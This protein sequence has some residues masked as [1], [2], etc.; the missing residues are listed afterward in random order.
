MDIE[1]RRETLLRALEKCL[2]PSGKEEQRDY[3]GCTMITVHANQKEPAASFYA[4]DTYLCVET[5]VLVETLTDPGKIAVDTKRLHLMASNMPGDSVHLVVRDGKLILTGDRRRRY[6][7]TTFDPALFPPL[8]DPS[9]EAP[10]IKM[11]GPMLAELM[12][13][14]EHGCDDSKQRPHLAGILL[15]AFTP[16]GRQMTAVEAVSM[17]GYKL[18]QAQANILVGGQLPFKAFL[19]TRLLKPLHGVLEKEGQISIALDNASVFVMTPDTLFGALLPRDPFINYEEMIRQ[20]HPMKAICS[21]P[22]VAMVDSLK[23]ISALKNQRDAQVR[24][25]F[26]DSTFSMDLVDAQ[27]NASD[28]LPVKS[29]SEIDS[30]VFHADPQYVLDHLKGANADCTLLET[31]M[32]TIAFQTEDGYFGFMVP[33]QPKSTDPPAPTSTSSTKEKGPGPGRGGKKKTSKKT[34]KKASRKP[35]E[36]PEQDE[37]EDELGSADPSQYTND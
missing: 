2:H 13:R 15:H 9:D 8:R 31:K 5:A 1:I 37:D 26:K 19:P 32:N 30:F 24:F 11:P 3:S 18:C 17:N 20:S 33:Q 28:V 21:L 29:K 22:T 27:T 25:E 36:Q 14:V 6:T 16:E 7:A 23:A 12:H 35:E 34:S 4:V 10:R